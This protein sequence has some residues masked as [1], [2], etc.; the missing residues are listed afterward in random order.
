MSGIVDEI[1]G[2]G[3]FDFIIMLFQCE[4]ASLFI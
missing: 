4:A 1:A 3:I 2:I